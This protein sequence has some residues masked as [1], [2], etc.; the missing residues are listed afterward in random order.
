MFVTQKWQWNLTF[1]CP[2]NTITSSWDT[3]HKTAH[4]WTDNPEEIKIPEYKIVESVLMEW[5]WQKLVFSSLCSSK[6][7]ESTAQQL[8]VESKPPNGWMD[9]SEKHSGTV[10][11]TAGWKSCS[12]NYKA[13]SWRDIIMPLYCTV[14]GSLPLMPPDALQPKAYCTNPGL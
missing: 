9:K 1:L 13:A 7:E 14:V 3:I 6:T 4:R 11:R 12:I 8:N 2:W 10:Y 5:F